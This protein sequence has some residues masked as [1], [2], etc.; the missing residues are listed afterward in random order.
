MAAISERCASEKL[1]AML[2]NI[3]DFGVSEFDISRLT[4][5]ALFDDVFGNRR[6]YLI[7]PEEEIAEITSSTDETLSARL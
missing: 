4:S 3:K 5:S 6:S 2:I 1:T 7:S